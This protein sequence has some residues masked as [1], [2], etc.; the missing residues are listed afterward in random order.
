MELTEAVLHAQLVTIVQMNLLMSLLPVLL[1]HTLLHL[2]LY[3][4]TVPMVITATDKQQLI[5]D[6]QQLRMAFITLVVL[7]LLKDLT[8]LVQ[9]TLVNLATT[10]LAMFKQLVLLVLT[11]LFMANQHH[12][13]VLKLLLVTILKVQQ[14]QTSMILHAQLVCTA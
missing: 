10:V 11:S 13:H 8:T 6:T 1:V 5:L 7:V 9:P 14:T 12:Q 3:V 4:K 2:L